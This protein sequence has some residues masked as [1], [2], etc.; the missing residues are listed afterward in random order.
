MVPFIFFDFFKNA[1]K[2]A[3]LGFGSLLL[4]LGMLILFFP[5]LLRTMI[6]LLLVGGALPLII[7][8]LKDDTGFKGPQPRQ[9]EDVRI[10][11]P[12]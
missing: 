5:E 10:I 3:A 12:E 9:D 8:G 1:G 6:G 11:Y 2:K 7:Y 4:I